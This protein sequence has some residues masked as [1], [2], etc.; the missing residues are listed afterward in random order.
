MA[1]YKPRT[2]APS[3][4]DKNFIH[5]TKGGYNYCIEIKDGSCLP[6]CVGYAW[7]RWREL[8][9]KYHNLSRR[10]AEMWWGNTDDGYKR[11]QTPKL[12]A[13]LCWAKGKVGNKEDG[14]GHVA[15]VEQINAD[16]SIVISNSDYSGRRFYTRTMKAPYSLGNKYTFQG[17]IY[18][19]VEFEIEKP[20]YNKGNYE[21]DCDLLNV[22]TGP[23]TN[24]AKKTFKQLTVN[25]QN[26]I[27]KL[28]NGKSANG[29]VKGVRCTISKVENNWGETPSG[30]ICLDYCKKF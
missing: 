1:T 28:N 25:A 15:I 8:L 7:G 6:N 4:T 14:A 19:P 26:Q 17:F 27:K 9:G 21:V 11:G 22:R 3:T 5:Y 10:N 2:T 20:S 24:F 23:G 16:G 29:Y 12:G 13:V 30:W 18:P